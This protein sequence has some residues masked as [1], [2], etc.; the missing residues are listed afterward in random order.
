MALIY[1]PECGTDTEHVTI[2]GAA[3][4]AH[5]TRTTIYNWLGRSRLHTVQR[6]S[7]RTLVCTRSLVI[8]PPAAS[9]AGQ[10]PRPLRVLNF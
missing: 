9:R 6:P 8:Y 7:G 2:S 5:V 1:C 3:R 10:Q 4:D